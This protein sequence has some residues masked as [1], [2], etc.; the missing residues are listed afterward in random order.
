M[1]FRGQGAELLLPPTGSV[2]LLRRAVDQIPTGGGT[3]L[4]ATLVAALEVAQQARRRGL[5]NVV[6]VLLTDARANVGLKA[7]RA[8]VEDE[9]RQLTRS[10]G[11]TRCLVAQ[12]GGGEGRQ[13]PRLARLAAE[14]GGDYRVVD[15]P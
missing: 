13:S 10:L 8:G 15:T 14:S 11:R 6:L 7:D 12:F 1:S 9:L 4:A 5:H 3:P 2:E